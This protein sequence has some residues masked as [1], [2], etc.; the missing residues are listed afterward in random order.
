M[1]REKLT[2]LTLSLETDPTLDQETTRARVISLMRQI[3]MRASMLIVDEPQDF[4]NAAVACIATPLVY[5]LLAYEK[6]VPYSEIVVGR[7]FR[8]VAPVFLLDYFCLSWIL[9]DVAQM[10]ATH[11]FLGLGIAYQTSVN[12]GK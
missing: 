8:F 4:L 9:P 6:G 11:I 7:A 5:L 1:L 12:D 2:K 10:T 3:E